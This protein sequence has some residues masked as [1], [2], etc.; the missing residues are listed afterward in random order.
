[1]AIKGPGADE[2]GEVYARVRVLC[3]QLGEEERLYPALYGLWVFHFVRAELDEARTLGEEFLRRTESEAT[4]RLAAHR[5][6]G[7][8]L[9]LRGELVE[10]CAQME[11]CVE[12]YDEAQ[13]GGLIFSYGQ[14]T[15]SNLSEI[16]WLRLLPSYCARTYTFR[17]NSGGRRSIKRPENGLSGSSPRSSQ[18][19]K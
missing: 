1:L 2:A 7:M 4:Q 8:A 12:L 10:A 6:L 5:V 18:N 16:H 9:F 3:E 14:L 19:A 15:F 11:Q 13:H 17:C